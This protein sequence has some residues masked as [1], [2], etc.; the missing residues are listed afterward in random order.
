[1]KYITPRWLSL[2][3]IAAL[4]VLLVACSGGSPTGSEGDGSGSTVNVILKDFSVSLDTSQTAA[5]IVTFEVKNDG[6][7]QHDFAIRG[8]GVEQNT[9]VIKPGEKA[10]LMVDLE[11][12]I[13][14]HVCTIPGH[15][16]LGMIGTFTVTSH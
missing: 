11:P 3:G 4:A 1:M 2:L 14:T 7:V 12:G 5:G 13:Y 6:S 10:T 9:P 15:E 16:Q 8:N